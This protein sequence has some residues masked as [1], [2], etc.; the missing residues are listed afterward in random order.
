VKDKNDQ[1]VGGRDK[2]AWRRVLRARRRSLDPARALA[3]AEAAAQHLVTAPEWADV[4][5][6]GLY[7]GRDGEMDTGPVQVAARASGRTLYLPCV[8]ADAMAFR[9]WEPEQALIVNRYGIDEPPGDAPLAPSL[10]LLLTPLVGW[11]H[12]GYRLGMGGG[13]FD[14]YLAVASER[15]GWVLGFAFDCQREDRLVDLQEPW[16]AAMDGVLTERGIERFRR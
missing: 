13:Y 3:A 14:R 2:R 9:R 5:H 12:G 4:R 6:I 16:D 8:E 7:L 1:S 10:D 11:A 15:P